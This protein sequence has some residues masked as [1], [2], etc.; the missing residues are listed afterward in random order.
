MNIKNVTAKHKQGK[1]LS[2][3]EIEFVV[4]SFVDG[5]VTEEEMTDFLQSIVKN[6]LTKEETFALTK[7]MLNSG[8]KMN[9]SHFS[10]TIDKHSTGGVSDSTTLIVV[11]LFALLGFSCLKMSGGALGHT[12]GTADKLKVFDGINNSPTKE[13]A[14]EIAKKT[15]A[16]FMTAT[17][18]IA[19]ADKKIYALRDKIN[20]MSIGLIASSIMSKKLASG[21]KNLILDVKYGNGA[22]VKTKKHATALAKL[23]TQIGKMYEVNTTYIL[24][25]MNQPLGQCVGNRLEVWEAVENLKS[26]Q[27]TR[28]MEHSLNIVALATHKV[29]GKTKKEVFDIA[30]KLLK[31]KKALE[32][33]KEIV[34]CQGG[35]FD[36]FNINSSNK[37]VVKS[38]K[39]GIISKIQTKSLGLLD[40]EFSLEA[41]NY[42]GYKICVQLGQKVLKDDVLFE[43]YFETQNQ[44]KITKKLRQ[45][46][47]I[48]NEN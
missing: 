48:K 10:N 21:A 13:K 1:T 8:E 23:M 2:E 20:A 35:K 45:T 30:Y 43:C 32:K 31:S 47:G 4:N 18:Q 42:I 9:L 41:K 17:G 16:C 40:K 15:G 44:E 36:V 25:K 37:F 38:T 26:G 5:D 24:G 33:L 27:M 34:L 39:S 7:V 11:P 46:I 3:Q 29:L 6:D 12:G 19:P 28:L 22:L 14:F